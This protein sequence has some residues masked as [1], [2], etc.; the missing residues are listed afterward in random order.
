MVK[1]ASRTGLRIELRILRVRDYGRIGWDGMEKSSE[2]LRW[3]VGGDAE[4][5]N[6]KVGSRSGYNA[7]TR[8]KFFFL[9]FFPPFFETIDNFSIDSI[10]LDGRGE[11]GE[12]EENWRESI[13]EL[14]GVR[15]S[16]RFTSIRFVRL[17]KLPKGGFLSRFYG[18]QS[19]NKERCLLVDCFRDST[20][21]SKHGRWM[22][23][24]RFEE[25]CFCISLSSEKFF[26]NFI[27]ASE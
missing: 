14:V 26:S 15:S 10:R 9:S 3:K 22:A 21:C 8:Y 1:I 17:R 6:N 5:D 18:W 27:V 16:K 20:A 25:A 24:F 2:K 11:G 4:L 12:G 13:L 23:L 7:E 19:L